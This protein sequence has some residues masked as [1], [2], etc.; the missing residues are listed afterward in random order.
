MRRL[1]NSG[2]GVRFNHL[3]DDVTHVIVGDCDDELKQYLKTTSQR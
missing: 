3:S 1:I 2:G